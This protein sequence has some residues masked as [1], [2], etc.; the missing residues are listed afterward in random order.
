LARVALVEA[1]P[2]HAVC[3][4][5]CCSPLASVVHTC[6]AIG[7]VGLVRRGI[8]DGAGQF[9]FCTHR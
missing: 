6:G 2:H 7:D 9:Y 8:D 3:T 5:Q 4:E 1:D